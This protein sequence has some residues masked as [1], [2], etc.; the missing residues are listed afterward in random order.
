MTIRQTTKFKSDKKGRQD[1]ARQAIPPRVIRLLREIIEYLWAGEAQ[2]YHQIPI[3]NRKGHIFRSIRHVAAWLGQRT[4][5]SDFFGGCP[6]CL[7]NDGYLN[8]GRDQW[9]FCRTHQVKWCRGANLISTWRMETEADWEENKKIL[10][11]F[12]TAEPAFPSPSD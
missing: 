2:D 5:G 4:G 10:G 1:A 7:R 9:F 3:G 8:V 11:E 6:T 12:G